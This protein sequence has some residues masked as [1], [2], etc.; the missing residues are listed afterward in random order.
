MGDP[1]PFELGQILG[2]MEEHLDSIDK[3]LENGSETMKE[4]KDEQV[5][6]TDCVQEIDKEFAVH[7]EKPHLYHV[8]EERTKF[9]RL[10]RHWLEV[11]IGSVLGIIGLILTAL[12]QYGVIN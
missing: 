7:Q 2:K 9:Q 10:K 12:N 8:T 1:P 5:K 6:I 11:A 4:I 3:S